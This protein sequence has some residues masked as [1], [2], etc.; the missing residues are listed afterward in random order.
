[1]SKTPTTFKTGFPDLPI[2]PHRKGDV[3]NQDL[4]GLDSHAGALSSFIKMCSTPMTIGVQ[5]DWGSGKTSLMNLIRAKLGDVRVL[6]IWFNTWQ[7][8]QFGHDKKLANSMLINLMQKI[9]AQGKPSRKVLHN[10]S[11]FIRGVV[12]SAASSQGMD[13]RALLDSIDGKG[14]LDDAGLFEQLK[15]DF[16]EVIDDILGQSTETSGFERVVIYIDD[17]DR[18][19][20]VKAVELLEAVKNLI[21]VAGCVFVLAIDYDV[22]IRGLRQKKG[23]H[24]EEG[25]E[26]EGKSFF[27]KII[28]VPYR[29]PIER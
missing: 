12:Q 27:D 4:L 16:T 17:L 11:R 13:G 5:G 1:M 28:Q 29:M 20:P 24:H 10:V 22:V 19:A 7:Y 9:H 18:L 8:S 3:D 6:N 15:D 21:D 23:Y 25:R 14:E 2:D 26:D